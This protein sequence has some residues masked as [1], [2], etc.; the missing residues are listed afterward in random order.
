MYVNRLKPS[1]H[2]GRLERWLGRDRIEHLSG[3][4]RGWYGPPICLLDCPGSV[5]M[6]KDGDFVGDFD[7]GFFHSAADGMRDYLRRLWQEAGKPVY[8]RST[9][10]A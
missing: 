9:L 10:N 3:H 6:G 5:W 1:V 4:M 7:R 8:H 2:S